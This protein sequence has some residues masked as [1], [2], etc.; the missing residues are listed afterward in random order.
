[1]SDIPHAREILE[2]LLI[3]MEN[4]HFDRMHVRA[5]VQAAL[6]LMYRKKHKRKKA[7]RAAKRVSVEIRDAVIQC[8]TE[9]PSIST[10]ELSEKYDVNQGR[11][12]EILAGQ[13][14]EYGTESTDGI[15]TERG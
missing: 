2:Q 7:P 11:I 10:R 4:G 8:V 13:Y 15:L 5:S 1:M 9:N 3:D 14:G 6:Q 12:S